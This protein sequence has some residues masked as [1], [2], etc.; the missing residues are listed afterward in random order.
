MTESRIVGSQA[1][2]SKEWTRSGSSRSSVC[3][4]ASVSSHAGGGGKFPGR[5]SNVSSKRIVG[6]GALGQSL[7]S[8]GT[9]STS[10]L[11]GVIDNGKNKE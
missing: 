6:S 7:R 5:S 4:N 10:R 11:Q 1:D 2:L 9:S 8:I 3:S